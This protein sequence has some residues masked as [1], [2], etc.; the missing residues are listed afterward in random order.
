[1]EQIAYKRWLS[2]YENLPE[3][4]PSFLDVLEELLLSLSHWT[5][6]EHSISFQSG[7]ISYGR[8]LICLENPTFQESEFFYSFLSRIFHEKIVFLKQVLTDYASLSLSQKILILGFDLHK[9]APR[10][11]VYFYV[12]KG[13]EYFP[14]YFGKEIFS[15][16]SCDQFIQ[17]YDISLDGE[18][19]KK[20]YL[21]LSKDTISSQQELLIPIF[22]EKIFQLF[23]LVKRVH[24]ALKWDGED[25][26][27]DFD[28]WWNQFFLETLQA[29]FGFSF[30]VSLIPQYEERTFTFLSIAYN[31]QTWNLDFSD[32]NI[33]FY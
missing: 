25:V 16:L 5:Y 17:W 2:Y 22:W 23:L 30:P 7:E 8:W 29:K 20:S 4:S 28:F 11:K 21:V 33:Y 18:L 19:R 32:Y 1:M 26:S 14:P 15:S 24:I 9:S 3:W 13:K 27:I 31:I 6:L 12:E 10:Y